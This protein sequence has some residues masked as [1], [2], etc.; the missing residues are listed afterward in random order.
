MRKGF[1]EMIAKK[2]FIYNGIWATKGKP[3]VVDSKDAKHLIEKG[4]I[5][6]EN[7]S[8]KSSKGNNKKSSRIRSRS[9]I[10]SEECDKESCEGNSDGTKIDIAEE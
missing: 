6:D 2:S 8:R 4:L 1:E 10:G 7:Q 3:I 9:S 5:E